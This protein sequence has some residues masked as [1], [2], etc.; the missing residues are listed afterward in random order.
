MNPATRWLTILAAL[1]VAL[2]LAI[3][4]SQNVTTRPAGVLRLRVRV[5][6]RVRR[7]RV[8]VWCVCVQSSYSFQGQCKQC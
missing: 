7:V 2:P 3:V 5:R 6:V 4:H 8:R 1:L